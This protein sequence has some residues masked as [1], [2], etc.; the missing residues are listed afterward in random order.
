MHGNQ[1]F[2]TQKIFTH[3]HVVLSNHKVDR[4][5]SNLFKTIVY[6]PM[7]EGIIVVQYL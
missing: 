3:V 7:K 2:I 6:K 1:I 4:Q 5:K